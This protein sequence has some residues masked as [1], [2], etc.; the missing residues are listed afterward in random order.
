MPAALGH[1]VRV[2]Y[3][4]EDNGFNA[5]PADSTYKTFGANV[6]FNRAEASNDP[7]KLFDPNDREAAKV[8]AQRFSG[9][10]SVEFT[11][12]NPWWLRTIFG[13]PSTTGTDLGTDGVD[14]R[15]T[16]TYNGKYGD[17]MQIVLGMEHA[18][19]QRILSGCVVR[20]ATVDVAVNDTVTVSLDGFYAEEQ[21]DT[22]GTGPAQTTFEDDP[23]T[24]AEASF[25]LN[26]AAVNLTQNVS[27]S[28]ENNVDPIGEL[29][30]RFTAD[31]APKV[32]APS[33][34]FS[35]V[36]KDNQD[37]VERL[38]GGTGSTSPQSYPEN[39]APITVSFDNGKTG[40]AMQTI[41]FDVGGAFRESYSLSGMADQEQQLR[42]DINEMAR[43]ITA[44]AEN[45]TSTAK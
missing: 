19:E 34:S 44:T 8:L 31:Y 39:E 24:F 40:S 30:T 6:K 7:V 10:W 4:W 26:G 23:Y 36:E 15:W 38:Y 28:I 5:A 17:S 42:S 45:D 22:T 41:Q 20:S 27:L 21:I 11:M 32:R 1:D 16:H 25:S 35:K 14:D 29:G 37:E 43:T 13:S 3:L 18:G 12:T 9:S 2:N 33:V